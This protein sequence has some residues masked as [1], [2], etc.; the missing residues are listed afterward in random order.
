MLAVA[1]LAG[2]AGVALAA[3]AAHKVESPALVAAANLLMI[4]AVAS[5]TL[6]AVSAGLG[7]RVWLWPA[8][9]M[10]FAVTLFSGTIAANALSPFSAP[11]MLA[12]MGGSLTILSWLAVAGL[13]A[14]E[15]FNLRGQD[16]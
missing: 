4:H 8:A 10:L 14:R 7:S 13:A 5:V 9:S 11:V 1:G 12:P 2:A 16:R 6:V 3:V 15:W